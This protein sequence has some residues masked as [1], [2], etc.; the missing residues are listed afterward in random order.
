MIIE[1]TESCIGC[2]KTIEESNSS[3]IPD[4]CYDCYFNVW[5]CKRCKECKFHTK[6]GQC[7]TCIYE[8]TDTQD[9]QL[10]K[11]FVKESEVANVPNDSIIV[12]NYSPEDNMMFHFSLKGGEGLTMLVNKK[13]ESQV[14]I[15][16][17]Q[18]GFIN[19]VDMDGH[20]HG[21]NT[22]SIESYKTEK[23]ENLGI[24]RSSIE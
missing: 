21:I 7:E 15:Q 4:L 14:V 23:F 22:E 6:N 19:W 17:N 18:K 2:N 16:I 13:W 24:R 9:E 20:G 10:L 1:K 11:E 5:L 12:Y 8:Q 3:R